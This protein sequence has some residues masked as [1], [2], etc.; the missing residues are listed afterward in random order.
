MGEESSRELAGVIA[1]VW[2]EVAQ[3]REIE[4]SEAD[5]KQLGQ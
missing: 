4:G 3:T 5:L 2:R 1:E